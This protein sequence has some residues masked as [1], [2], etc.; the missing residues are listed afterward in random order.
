MRYDVLL[1]SS[2]VLPYLHAAKLENHFPYHPSTVLVMSGETLHMISHSPLSLMTFVDYFTLFIF[3]K[4]LIQHKVMTSAHRE[5]IWITSYIKILKLPKI[6]H[7]NTKFKYCHK[8]HKWKYR[9][10][11]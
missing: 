10:F 3:P 2:V 6:M 11:K 9:N 7:T 1:F 8:T 5:D 4:M